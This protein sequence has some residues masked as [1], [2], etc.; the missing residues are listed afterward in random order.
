MA[1]GKA[2]RGMAVAGV[3][4]TAAR[5]AA[6]FIEDGLMRRSIIRNHIGAKGWS[7]I[8][9]ITRYKMHWGGALGD[10]FRTESM[11]WVQ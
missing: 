8:G 6:G 3:I 7:C 2:G 10:G 11:L 5:D 1:A 4:W 9:V